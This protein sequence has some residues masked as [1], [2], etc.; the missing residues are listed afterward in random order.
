MPHQSV[1]CE[2]YGGVGVIGL[3]LLGRVKELRLSDINPFLA[4]SMDK[5]IG[6]LSEVG[7]SFIT[8]TPTG[9]PQSL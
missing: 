2:L 9:V 5:I 1:V 6:Q 8:T 4:I 7:G 3:N